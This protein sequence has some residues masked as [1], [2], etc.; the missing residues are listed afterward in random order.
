MI[1]T[2]ATR[3]DKMSLI[4]T[5]FTDISICE[6]KGKIKDYGRNIQLIFSF[7]DADYKGGRHEFRDFY[8]KI[9]KKI[10]GEFATSHIYKVSKE[11]SAKSSYFYEKE[12]E[13]TSSK[14]NI[15]LLLA[16]K[17]PV[18]ESTAYSLTLI[19]EYYP[20]R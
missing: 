9:F 1:E 6:E 11:K 18:D 17:D 5:Y 7:S 10:K 2:F 3:E 4:K 15:K 14:S 19:F 20:K 16:Y 12:K 13:I 8:K